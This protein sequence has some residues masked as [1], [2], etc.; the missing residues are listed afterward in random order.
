MQLISQDGRGSSVAT[1]I[2]AAR[3][4]PALLIRARI[5][6]PTH[7]CPRGIRVKPPGV[8]ACAKGAGLPAR[9]VRA[10]SSGGER[11]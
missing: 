4:R 6:S 1:A 3:R 9:E 10:Q 5:R 7:A 8:P 2:A 11:T